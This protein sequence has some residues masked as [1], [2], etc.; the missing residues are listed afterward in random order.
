MNGAYVLYIPKNMLLF[1][2][3]NDSRYTSKQFSDDD[4]K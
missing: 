1:V 4:A 3:I 2:N